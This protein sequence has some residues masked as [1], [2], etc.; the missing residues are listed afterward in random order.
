MTNDIALGLQDQDDEEEALAAFAKAVN[1]SW[2][3]EWSDLGFYEEGEFAGWGAA[4]YR[5]LEVT[6]ARVGRIHFN[7]TGLDIR[8]ALA[9]DPETWV[10]R[11]TAWELQQIVLRQD[12]FDM[13]DFYLN[14]RRITRDET[15]QFGIVRPNGVN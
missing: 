1:A 8:D 3:G 10:G 14:G 11:Y 15:E 9:G 12:L 6:R 13:T 2:M 7:L 4:F 5:V